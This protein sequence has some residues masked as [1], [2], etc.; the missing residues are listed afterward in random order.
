MRATQLADAGAWIPAVSKSHFFLSGSIAPYHLC[1]SL[2]E[3]SRLS[4]PQDWLEQLLLFLQ[5]DRERVSLTLDKELP[6]VSQKISTLFQAMK[7]RVVMGCLAQLSPDADLLV[8]VYYCC[9]S[10][11]FS[12]CVCV[13]VLA[14]VYR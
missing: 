11:L 12:V 3:G 9:K 13:Y 6:L 10:C 1:H 7:T 14:S 8:V 5:C 2:L 4:G